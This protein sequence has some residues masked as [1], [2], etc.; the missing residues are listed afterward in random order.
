MTSDSGEWGMLPPLHRPHTCVWASALN[1]LPALCV[2]Y[3]GA[4]AVC[5]IFVVHVGQHLKESRSF[6]EE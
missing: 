3:V 4:V 2:L 1:L 6:I 5:S